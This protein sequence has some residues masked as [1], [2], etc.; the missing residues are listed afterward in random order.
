MGLFVWAVAAARV[1]AV[2]ALHVVCG[3]EDEVW[4]FVVEVFRRQ[5]RGRG[6]C[7]GFRPPGGG[8]RFGFVGHYWNN[9]S[10]FRGSG[11]VSS[12]M[13]V[14]RPALVLRVVVE[15]SELGSFSLF[16]SI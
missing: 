10:S 9:L 8:D 3:G 7:G 2:A 1:A 4:A 12:G 15:A 13:G 6:G 14:L 5:L 11:G 16:P